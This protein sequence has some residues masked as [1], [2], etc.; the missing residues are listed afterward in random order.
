M[1]ATANEE[2]LLERPELPLVDQLRRRLGAFLVDGFFEGASRAGRLVPLSHPR[3]HGVEV[4]RDVP[5]LA[6]GLLEHRLDVWRPKGAAGLPVVLY[7]HGGAFRILSKESHWLFGLIFARRGFVAFNISYRLAP[8]HRFPAAVQ[9]ACAAYEWVVRNAERFG[10]DPSRI[11]LAGESAGANLATALTLSTCYPRRE[12][13]ARKVFELGVTPRAVLPA[14]GVFQVSDPER[15]LREHRLSRFFHDRIAEMAD[16]YLHGARVPMPD[17]LDLAD[18]VV[19]LERG[20]PPERPLPPFFLSCGTR[21]FLMEDSRRMERAL[22]RL[23]V[24]FEARYYAG[25]IHA[26]H[27]FVLRASARRCWRDAFGFLER[28]VPGGR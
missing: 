28:H 1:D 7:M 24:P 6:G 25:E 15:Y 16:A 2:Q 19:A 26:F 3:L 9:D 21:D 20:V 5:Y 18:P 10:G 27:A 22:S 4:I 14:C 23:K 12:P 17:G 8:R 13:W 11:V